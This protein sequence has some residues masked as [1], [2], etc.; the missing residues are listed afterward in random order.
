MR[1]DSFK[2]NIGILCAFV[3]G[4][5]ALLMQTRAAQA[6][7]ATGIPPE[8]GEYSSYSDML[9]TGTESRFNPATGRVEIVVLP[10]AMPVPTPFGNLVFRADGGYS[11][12]KDAKVR[13][14]WIFNRNTNRL[15]FTGTFAKTQVEYLI[16]R[17]KYIIQ[18]TMARNAK[19][20]YRFI[21]EKKA[22]RPLPVSKDLA[23]GLK[24]VLVC[25]IELKRIALLD[26]GTGKVTA[27]LNGVG[28]S[29]A[30]RTGEI[31]CLDV[32]ADLLSPPL[33]LLRPDG[34]P[35]G[36]LPNEPKDPKN[37]SFAIEGLRLGGRESQLQFSPDGGMIACSGTYLSAEARQQMLFSNRDP[38][39]AIL[40]RN[41]ALV[42]LIT[43]V[44]LD[45]AF[46]WT[47][48]GRL[49]YANSRNQLVLTDQN[50][51]AARSLS[52]QSAE[53]IAV[54]PD[55]KQMVIA[56][57]KRLFV[58]NIESG[59]EK[60]LNFVLEETTNGALYGES[61]ERLDWSP[62]GQAVVA[63]V[64]FLTQYGAYLVPLDGRPAQRVKQRNG[65]DLVLTGPYVSWGKAQ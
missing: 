20:T 32:N 54:S 28:P 62:D 30:K 45:M 8:P 13:G 24:G 58:R 5:A 29:Q 10:H 7:S 65:D 56:R 25:E 36:S 17:G 27:T 57:S 18:I 60:K 12:K 40:R 53:A 35:S 19:G 15:S 2:R 31:V 26:L 11:A 37:R 9:V 4:G 48:D 44:P 22:A 49:A 50:F 16:R 47:G 34:S 63:T 14:R 61:I 52:S 59:G 51:H 23:G 42:T 3:L 33:A 39:I 64:R 41:G 6:Q 43:D 21:C 1:F 38:A 55:S 46:G